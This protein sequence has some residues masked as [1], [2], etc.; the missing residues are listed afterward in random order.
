MASVVD[1]SLFACSVVCVTTWSSEFLSV[2]C[3]FSSKT[4]VSVAVCGFCAILVIFVRGF[5]LSLLL[6][7][8][9]IAFVLNL[10]G[11]SHIFQYAAFNMVDNNSLSAGLP[12]EDVPTA[13][14]ASHAPA[15][16]L[17]SSGTPLSADSI[18]DAVLRTLGSSVPTIMASIQ[19]NTLSSATNTEPPSCSV[20]TGGMSAV[21]IG[22][23]FLA[24]SSGAFTLPAFVP[25]FTPVSA[26]SNSSTACLVAPITSTSS[27]PS[28][29]GHLPCSESSS[30]WL[31]TDRAFIVGPGHAP[32]Q[33]KLVAKIRRASSWN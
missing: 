17:S 10:I 13:S 23:G 19:G 15:S 3:L 2:C 31:K 26:I 14:S 32:I 21:G 11:V 4:L 20:S 28:S 25:T 22:S 7:V 33:A 16:A 24:P 18:A 9:C 6:A 29:L 1:K 30:L 5:S 12:P 8:G 27:S